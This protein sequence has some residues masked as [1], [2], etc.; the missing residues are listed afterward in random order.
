MTI[1]GLDEHLD[2]YGDPGGDFDGDE[3]PLGPGLAVEPDPPR[4]ETERPW[5]IGPILR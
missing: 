1:H 3:F 2:N 5:H 4:R